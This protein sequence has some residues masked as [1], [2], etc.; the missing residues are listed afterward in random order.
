MENKEDFK[1]ASLKYFE[2]HKDTITDKEADIW[3][4]MATAKIESMM[5]KDGENDAICIKLNS[6]IFI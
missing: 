5:Y 2:K 1:S 6:I 3:D 4:F